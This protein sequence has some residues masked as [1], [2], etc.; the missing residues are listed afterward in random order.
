[1]STLH[2]R[3]LKVAMFVAARKEQ[4]DGACYLANTYKSMSS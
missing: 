4:V 1:M 2:R 3:L